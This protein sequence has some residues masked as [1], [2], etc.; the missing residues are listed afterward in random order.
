M[1]LESRKYKGERVCLCEDG[2]YMWTYSL[3]MYTN[4]AILLVVLK[5]FGILW[6][7]ALLTLFV[8]PLLRGETS[9][10][11]QDL[12]IWAIVL[13]VFLA[14]CLLAYLIV[15]RMY[16]GRYVVDFTMDEKGIE[17]KQAA[18]AAKKARKMAEGTFLAGAASGRPG[19]MGAG[20]L[21]SRTELSS[22]FSRVRRIRP[23]PRLH[24]IK[25]NARFSH[26]QVYVPAED[27][28]FVLDFIRTHCP[29]VK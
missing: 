1:E 21:A 23:F 29:Q 24:L 27:F 13:A 11:L 6:A 26:N 28:P 3:N 2:K 14:V 25:V 4:P 9:G 12:K 22:D 5:I 8:P 7:A 17:H 16:G 20:V 19:V 15:A 18:S 10:M